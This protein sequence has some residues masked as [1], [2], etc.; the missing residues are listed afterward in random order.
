MMDR[1]RAQGFVQG[2]RAERF[3]AVFVVFPC[4]RA[5]SFR[6]PDDFVRLVRNLD[7]T[8]ADSLQEQGPT[9]RYSVMFKYTL[10]T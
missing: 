1:N 7:S 9:F 3:G 10:T 8:A 6:F 4:L 5:A 2:R